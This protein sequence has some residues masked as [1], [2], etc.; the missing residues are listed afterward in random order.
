MISWHGYWA[1]CHL[2]TINTLVPSFNCLILSTWLQPSCMY[3]NH[4][5]FFIKQFHELHKL[6]NFSMVDPGVEQR[7]THILSII[8][9]VIIITRAPKGAL[10]VLGDGLISNNKLN[11]II[12]NHIL[13]TAS[14]NINHSPS[15][16]QIKESNLHH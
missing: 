16:E 12:I 13:F 3:S 6:K 7:S 9:F 2:F 15:Y 14:K 10:T 1:A 11:L 4:L 5:N 8:L